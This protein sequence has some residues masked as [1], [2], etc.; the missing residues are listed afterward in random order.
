M[1]SSHLLI[2]VIAAATLVALLPARLVENPRKQ[3]MMTVWGMPFEDLLFRDRYA[4]GFEKL[5]PG[6]HVQYQRY[7]D[8]HPKYE[9]WHAVGRGADVMRT[10][11][12][13]YHGMVAKGE[14]EPLE[15]F[16]D[17][18]KVGLTPAEQADFFPSVWN[19]LVV[20]GQH[21]ALPSDNAQYG[22]YYNKRL[23]DIYNAAHPEAP[24]PYPDPNG[25]W[26]WADLKRMHEALTIMGPDGEIRQYGVSFELWAWPFLTFF[27][28]AGGRIWDDAQTTT[29]IDSEAGVEALEFLVALIPEH[30]PIRNPIEMAAVASG[31]DALFKVG[32]L[33]VLLDGSWRAPNI[34][35]EA[36]DLDFAI[37]PLPHGRKRAV[38]SGS[39]LWA[40]SAHSPNKA[41]AWEMIKWLTRPA[42]SLEYWNT[43]R[44]A[45]PAQFSIINS[46][47]FRHTTGIVVEADGGP[48]DVGAAR[49]RVLV[50]SLPQE[51]FAERAA[52]LRYATTPDPL[53]GEAPGFIP[54]APYEADLELKIGRALVEAVR[55]EKTARQALRDAARHVHAIID[56]DRAAKGL[57]AVQHEATR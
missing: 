35:Q 48:A 17:D 45:P 20:N 55:G 23:F 27:V 4:R 1:R 40:I 36:P 16:I 24:L 6:L 53:T 30:A 41:L 8:V 28:Q 50:P 2:V 49:Q 19:A 39:V 57:A 44:V 34:E 54:V 29:F 13:Y 9:A 42:Q 26:T 33:A 31:P 46:P 32:R 37:A 38:I 12:T 56:R 3:L 51:K 18:P 25:N 11:I 14:L 47:D 22:V 5:H 10:A 7:Y 43:L 15:H 52:W 21:F